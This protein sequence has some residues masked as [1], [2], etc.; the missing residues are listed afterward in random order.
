[1]NTVA[2]IGNMPWSD[3]CWK[4]AFYNPGSEA[5]KLRAYYTMFATFKGYKR[6]SSI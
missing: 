1:M 2:K 5:V 6:N 4:I 3:N